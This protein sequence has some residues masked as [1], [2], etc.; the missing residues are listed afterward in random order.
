[1]LDSLINTEL[2]GPAKD[3]FVITTVTSNHEEVNRRL[4]LDI[5]GQSLLEAFEDLHSCC[6][7]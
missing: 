6:A 5:G 7:F 2:I 1:M 4:M 3:N